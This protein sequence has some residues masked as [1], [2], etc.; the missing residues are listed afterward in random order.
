VS[1]LTLDGITARTITTSWLT[2]RVL[3]A[4]DESGEPVLFLHGN[5]SNATWWEDTMRALPPGFWGI[6]PD[7]RGFGAADP[8]KKIDAT[9][10]MGDL[11]DDAIALLD[12]LGIGKAHVVGNSLGGNVV[13][14]LLIDAVDRVQS[15]I[16]PGPGS[17]WGFGSTKDTDGTP[18]YDDF[19]GSG[20]GLFNY[21]IVQAIR[22]RDASLDRWYSPRRVLRDLV[23]KHIPER[24]DALVEA[25]LDVHL[26]PQDLRG[27]VVDSP[28]WPGFAP[29]VWGATNALSPKYAGDLTPLFAE[30][31][32]PPVLWIRGAED[33]AVADG[34][35]S[36][37]ATLGKQ[38][39]A[40]D[41]PGEE[42]FPP[43][44]MLGQTR[45]VLERYAATGGCYEE[46]VIDD[47]GHI[48]F[49]EKPDEFDAVFHRF[50]IDQK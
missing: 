11:A 24:E 45:A 38:G 18:C 29:G 23:Y 31:P 40:P 46:V 32:K 49:L 37:F 3:F 9:R 10:G 12:H 39:I 1:V 50:L 35:A 42:V 44:P 20:G 33:V 2:T 30:R 48:P 19:A 28:N 25:L 7:Q 4:G 8:A 36:D 27:D 17:P 41:Y 34:A 43:Q 16:A 6:A 47:S 26:G 22:D 14:Q 21:R 13:W 5:M 15:V